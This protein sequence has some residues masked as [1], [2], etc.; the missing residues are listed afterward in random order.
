MMFPSEI[1]KEKLSPDFKRLDQSEIDCTV[2]NIIDDIKMALEGHK[3]SFEHVEIDLTSLSEFTQ[4]VLYIIRTIPWGNTLTYGE[5]ARSI[6]RPKT[7]RAVGQALKS[8]PIPIIV[9]CHRVIRSD[10]NIGGFSV[11][12]GNK[13]KAKLL[14]F[15]YA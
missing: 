6:K 8:N 5:V 2:K 1:L 9:P 12:G 13:L 7:Y 11:E 3:R 14:D 4:T 10:G 15:E